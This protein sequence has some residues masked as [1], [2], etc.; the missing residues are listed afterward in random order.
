MRIP[1]GRF[2]ALR[3]ADFADLRRGIGSAVHF[4]TMRRNHVPR[5]QGSNCMRRFVSRRERSV[6]VTDAKAAVMQARLELDISGNEAD[7]LAQ[8]MLAMLADRPS[9]G[10]RIGVQS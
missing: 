10:L 8:L 9:A 5:V 3:L 1:H 4:R 7:T 6:T 2:V